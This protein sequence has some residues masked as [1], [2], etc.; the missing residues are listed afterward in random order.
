MKTKN[1]TL[2]MA[3][4]LFYGCQS[5]DLD[6]SLTQEPSDQGVIL[7]SV[8]QNRISSE[9]STLQADDAA[10]VALNF[11]NGQVK[12]KVSGAE[13][14]SVVPI[15]GVSEEI[16]LYAVNLT[17]GYVL[18]SSS[19]DTYP[20]YGYAE[21]GEFKG[22]DTGTGMDV[23]LSEYKLD[24]I[25][26]DSSLTFRDLWRRYEQ[27]PSLPRITTRSD[28]SDDYYDILYQYLDDWYNEGYSVNYLHNQPE[29]MPDDLY[30]SF[31]QDAEWEM[32]DMP[33]YP[34]MECA[35]ITYKTTSTRYEVYPMLSTKWNQDTPFNDADPLGRYLGCTTV[36][37]GQIMRYHQYPLKYPDTVISIDWNLM[38]NNTSNK[39]LSEF[40]FQFRSDIGVDNK[41]NATLSKLDNAIRHYGYSTDVIRHNSEKVCSE[42]NQGWPVCMTGLKSNGG[43]AWV[44]DGYYSS[45]E[46]TEY[47]LYVVG[48][49]DGRPSNMMQYDQQC[50]Y[51]FGPKFFHMNWGW[52]G[53]SDG[54]FLDNRIAVP[55]G[56]YS[57]DRKDILIHIK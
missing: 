39:T 41:G 46:T 54:Y 4:L 47:N 3:F 33:G 6:K 57:T 52:A 15:Y 45:D 5:K 43:H 12:T 13:V 24:R 2:L 35:I 8:N 20:I 21:Q 38:P 10:K 51:N 7:L 27:I 22:E 18:V 29:G 53:T 32:G 37:A 31:C 14:K 44:C 23:L 30:E 56:D 36:A 28:I 50:L 16:V 17:D 1:V 55:N 11:Y 42:L 48:Y 49:E 9:I 25:P 26:S 40:L 19:K 34:Y